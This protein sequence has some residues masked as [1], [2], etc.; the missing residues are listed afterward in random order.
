MIATKVLWDRVLGDIRMDTNKL[1]E[2]IFKG[3]QRPE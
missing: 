3:L 1:N 2:A